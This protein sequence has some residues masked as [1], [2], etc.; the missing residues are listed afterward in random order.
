MLCESNDLPEL[1]ASS[2]GLEV[3]PASGSSVGSVILGSGF[4]TPQICFPPTGHGRS[5]GPGWK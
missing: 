3:V 5:S 1:A 4:P 2:L